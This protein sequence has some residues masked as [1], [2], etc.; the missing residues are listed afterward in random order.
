MTSIDPRFRQALFEA[1]AWANAT[2][3]PTKDQ[4]L[5]VTIDV[6]QRFAGR[7]VNLTLEIARGLQQGEDQDALTHRAVLCR[8]AARL[9]GASGPASNE[10]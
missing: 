8:V 7:D 6:T 3:W 9:I 10:S 1:I 5:L 2:G 4:D